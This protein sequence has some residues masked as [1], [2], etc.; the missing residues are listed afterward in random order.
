MLSEL[1]RFLGSIPADAGEANPVTKAKDSIEVDPRGCGGGGPS[2]ERQALPTGRSPRMRGRQTGIW[3]GIAHQGSIPA[4][5]GEAI[6][7]EFKTMTSWVDPRGC[8]GGTER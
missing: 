3:I 1:G 8:G 4:D 5:A 6:A 7:Q 2:F